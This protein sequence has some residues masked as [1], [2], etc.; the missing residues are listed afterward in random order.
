MLPCIWDKENQS[1][2][3]SSPSFIGLQLW[4]WEPGLRHR[5][6]ES[7]VDERT[8]L[9]LSSPGALVELIRELGMDSLEI[10]KYLN[11]SNF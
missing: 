10:I 3:S 4:A 1:S 5:V 11:Y 2:S 6:T 8:P 7:L 9:N